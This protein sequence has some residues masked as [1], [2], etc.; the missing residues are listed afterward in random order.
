MTVSHNILLLLRDHGP[1]TRREIAEELG[2]K[3]IAS[4]ASVMQ[5]YRGTLVHISGY[6][7]DSDGGRLYPRALYKYGPGV[8]AKRPRPLPKA[9]YNK[10]ARSKCKKM[11]SSV[12][13]LA[14][15]SRKRQKKG[16]SCSSSV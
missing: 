9:E 11:V 14:I 12:F 16:S 1:L 3:A 4:L 10:R 13:D 6:R 7:R 2:N 8:D 5:Q 15:P